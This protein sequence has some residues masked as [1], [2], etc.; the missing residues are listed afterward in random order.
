MLNNPAVYMRMRGYSPTTLLECAACP[1][2]FAAETGVAF[3]A[4]NPNGDSVMAAFC[5]NECYL[6]AIPAEVLHRA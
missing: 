5:C 2:K 3:P 4:R 6:R 1:T